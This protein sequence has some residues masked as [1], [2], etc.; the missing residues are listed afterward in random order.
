MTTKILSTAAQYRYVSYKYAT[1]LG[2]ETSILLILQII[3]LI[4]ALVCLR[5]QYN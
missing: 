5:L 2:N 4:A 1:Y 3:D